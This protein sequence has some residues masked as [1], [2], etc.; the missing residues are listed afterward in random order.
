VRSVSAKRE[1]K[2]PV[3]RY[4]GGKFLL[5]PW[6]GAHLCPH[7]IYVES[8]GGGGSV[9]MYKPR[10]AGEVY[11]DLDGELVNVF[12][13]LRDPA[14]ARELARLV[15]LTPYARAEFEASALPAS[16]PI[17]AARRVLVRSYLGF[18][19]AAA[20]PTRSVTRTGFRATGH[21]RKGAAAAMD[22]A[23]Y[24]DAI[25]SFVERL[26]GVTIE[27]RPAL[28]V[29]RQQDTDDALH[30]VDPPYVHA[31]RS[32]DYQLAYRFEMSDEEH[33]ELADVLHSVKG[34][35]VLSGYHSELYDE[36][37]CDWHRVERRTTADCA[38]E[39]TE[40]L[41]LSPT[42][43]ARSSQLTLFSG[44]G[45]SASRNSRDGNYLKSQ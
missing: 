39:R 1:I 36:L 28:E 13:V 40:V 4:F 33:R 12:R 38:G 24:P 8:Y 17:E 7:R 27:N 30:Y 15:T 23:N 45:Q 42:A 26:R 6:I 20:Q 29:I 31:S 11:N 37:Y 5:A 41:W 22:W 14:Q 9:L 34:A 2:R 19:P 43:V 18:S 21:R 32:R 44:G 3:L 35:V 25:P 10:S 16:D